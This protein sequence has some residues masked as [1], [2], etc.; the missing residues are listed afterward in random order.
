MNGRDDFVIQRERVS[1]L[2]APVCYGS[3]LVSNPD[4]SKKYNMGDIGKKMTSSS[5]NVPQDTWLSSSRSQ[6]PGK[7]RTSRSL[8]SVLP[9]W[10][11]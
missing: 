9:A 7:V 6:P 1:K 10:I 3:S 11:S 2:V 8:A 5:N 4:I